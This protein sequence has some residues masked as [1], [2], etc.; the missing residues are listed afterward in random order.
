MRKTLIF[1]VW[2]AL[3][4][5]STTSEAIDFT[6][7]PGNVGDP[8]G[9]VSLTSPEILGLPADG[10]TVEWHFVFS[11]MKYVE[12]TNP[13]EASSKRSAANL[14]LDFGAGYCND[15]DCVP[16]QR[17]I[18]GTQIMYLSDKNGDPISGTGVFDTGVSNGTDTAQY[19]IFAAGDQNNPT[20]T[21]YDLYFNITL[22]VVN[23]G[24]GALPTI[25]SARLSLANAFQ[26]SII[27]E[28]NPVP[29]PST[30]LLLLLE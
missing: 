21:F 10:R 8:A 4:L 13:F 29:D 18:L 28:S 9:V 30:M 20:L 3:T 12:L 24:G 11:D 19:N 16:F 27:G 7:D 2:V 15:P 5:A 25:T 17:P 14:R 22:P 6:I 23:N 26:E 1:A